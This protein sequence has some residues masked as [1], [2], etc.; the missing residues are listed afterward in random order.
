MFLKFF[1]RG[2]HAYMGH[3]QPTNWW[4]QCRDKAAIKQQL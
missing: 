2:K 1:F 4:Q 3:F